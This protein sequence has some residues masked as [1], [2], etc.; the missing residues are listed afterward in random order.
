MS[1]LRVAIVTSN[2]RGNAARIGHHLA[3]SVDG[4]AVVGAVVDTG[5]AADRGRQLRRLRAWRR[6][7]GTSYLLWRCWLAVR[8]RIDPQPREFYDRTLAQLGEE[9]CFPVL[10]VPNVNSPQARD[11]LRSL[12][13]DLGVSV[14]NRVLAETTFSIPRLGMVNLHHG[15]VPDYRG[16]PAG[17][18]E[19]YNDEPVMG[20]SVHRIDAELDHGELLGRA[21]VPLAA[22]D[23]PRAAME[24]AYT[25]DA[26]LMGAV[27]AA[28]AAGTSMP[29]AVDFADGTVR[30][31]PSRAQVRELQR[32]LG[33]PVRHDDFRRARL[34]VLPET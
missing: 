17:F 1:E 14:G 9:Y 13:A 11:A 7:G 27:V 30:T 22:G 3:R 19:I 2:A 18:W 5:T 29:I 32:R 33:R 16:G 4:V 20:V 26:G 24:R 8:A 21:E 34:P 12:R 25:V 15:R 6:H 28:I 31:L 10:R 23:D